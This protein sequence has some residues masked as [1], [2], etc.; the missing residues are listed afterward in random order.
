MRDGT[1]VALGTPQELD[2]KFIPKERVHLDG[3]AL[4]FAKLET[5]YDLLSFSDLEAKYDYFSAGVLS[6]EAKMN[7]NGFYVTLGIGLLLEEI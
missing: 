3:H 4:F 5:G 1:I 6:D 7:F 2:A